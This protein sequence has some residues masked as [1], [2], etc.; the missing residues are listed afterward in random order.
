MRCQVR[1]ELAPSDRLPAI[2]N[3]AIL[4]SEGLTLIKFL[5][6]GRHTV[7]LVNQLTEGECQ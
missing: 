1:A 6:L 4:P 2:D 3:L 5:L 7:G